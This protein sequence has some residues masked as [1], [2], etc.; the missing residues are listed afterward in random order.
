MLSADEIIKKLNDLAL[1]IGHYVV[2]GSAVMTMHGLR[3]AADI[4]LLVSSELYEELKAKGWQEHIR[5]QSPGRPR[6]LFQDVFDAGD[7]WWIGDYKPV[8][9]LLISSPHMIKGIPF[10]DLEDIL[11]WKQAAGRSKDIKDIEL[12]K[13]LLLG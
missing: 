5:P 7:S 1:P 4:D 10:V 3:S 2:V 12:I 13:S 9:S 8:S 11:A 6:S